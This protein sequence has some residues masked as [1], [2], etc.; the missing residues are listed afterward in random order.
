MAQS[1]FRKIKED[2][3]CLKNNMNKLKCISLLG[4]IVLLCG[5]SSKA[6]KENIASS[7][8]NNVAENKTLINR[9]GTEY[10]WNC[11]VS[12]T[13]IKDINI[14][15]MRFISKDGDL[16]EFDLEKK[17]SSTNNNCKKVDTDIKFERFIASTIISKDNKIYRY[18]NS[19]LLERPL[20]YTG[21]FQYDYFDKNNNYVIFSYVNNIGGFIKDN[22]VYVYKLSNN[23]STIISE[24]E[25]YKF[26]DDEYYIGTYGELIKTN[27]AYYIYGITNKKECSDFADVKCEY[28]IVKDEELTNAYNDIQ[29]TNDYYF[30]FKD[31]DKI[32]TTV[33]GG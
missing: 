2:M 32:Y 4:I 29:Y 3:T 21:G 16:Y 14:N 11:E 8:D 20:E 15:Y 25:I 31:S 13:N 26:A 30:I 12:L 10:D 22:K 23:D 5:C 6:I 24:K 9:R 17:F 27:K 18:E 1:L 7:S 19:K 28:G 33:Y